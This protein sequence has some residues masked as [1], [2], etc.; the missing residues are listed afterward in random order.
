VFSDLNPDV[1]V[2]DPDDVLSSGEIGPDVAPLSPS[3]RPG[4]A[5]C[6]RGGIGPAAHLQDVPAEITTGVAAPRPIDE[7]EMF[8]D[9]LMSLHK[10]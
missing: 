10:P 3:A 7:G 5:R 9:L 6:V 2:S 1:R 8:S 4:S